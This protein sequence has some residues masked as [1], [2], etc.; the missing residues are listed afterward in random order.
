MPD[1]QSK[2]FDNSYPS[3]QVDNTNPEGAFQ[4]FIGDLQAS[5]TTSLE[6]PPDQK[7]LYY[8]LIKENIFPLFSELG[9]TVSEKGEPSPTMA[10]VKTGHVY[11]ITEGEPG[12]ANYLN[13]FI[14]SPNKPQLLEIG[15][16]PVGKVTTE[17]GMFNGTNN[18]RLSVLEDGRVVCENSDMHDSGTILDATESL[19]NPLPS[20]KLYPAGNPAAWIGKLIQQ[21][22]LSK[23]KA[24]LASIPTPPPEAASTRPNI[25]RR[26]FNR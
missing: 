23:A 7:E 25:I 26:L 5:A 13:I 21:G 20:H 9:R 10:D 15:G 16:K 17:L 18:I 14:T 22:T 11:N 2:G 12:E 6:L 3:H 19:F 1:E 4:T 8:K 24:E